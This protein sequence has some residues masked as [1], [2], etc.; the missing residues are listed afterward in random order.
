MFLPLF[1]R[2]RGECWIM[3]TELQGFG[4]ALKDAFEELNYK[5]ERAVIILF[6][7]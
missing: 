6:W 1:A 4:D 2:L 5:N 3:H 7:V